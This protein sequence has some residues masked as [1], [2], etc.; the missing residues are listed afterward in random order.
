MSAF[1]SAANS[2]LD[3]T[4]LVNIRGKFPLTALGRD[5]LCGAVPQCT[6]LERQNDSVSQPIRYVR[7]HHYFTNSDQLGQVVRRRLRRARRPRSHCRGSRSSGQRNRLPHSERHP[8]GHPRRQR[9]SRP[10]RNRLG[11]DARLLHSSRSALG[12]RPTRRQHR[13]VRQPRPRPDT[14]SDS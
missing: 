11:Q 2:P 6:V 14:G 3:D 4:F 9:R 12:R 13:T 1:D 7:Y 5:G 10:R 8:A